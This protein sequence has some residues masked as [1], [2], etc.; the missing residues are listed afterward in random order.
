MPLRLVPLSIFIELLYKL[1][2]PPAA[3]TPQIPALLPVALL[4]KIARR[5]LNI[6]PDAAAVMPIPATI[7]FTAVVLVALK[8]CKIFPDI[9]CPA[10]VAELMMP[11]TV[12]AAGDPVSMLALALADGV[13]K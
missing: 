9:I 13:L 2:E 3:S 5:L 1:N 4:V 6:L 11:A 10:T 12:A 7:V 8:S